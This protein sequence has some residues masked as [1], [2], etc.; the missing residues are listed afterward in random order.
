M[1]TNSPRK[2]SLAVSLGALFEVSTQSY[3]TPYVVGVNGGMLQ[4]LEGV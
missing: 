1:V 2:D 3:L 4:Y